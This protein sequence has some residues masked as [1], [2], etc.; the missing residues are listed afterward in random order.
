MRSKTRHGVFEI[1]QLE[2]IK[3][4]KSDKNATLHKNVAFL[5]KFISIIN[6]KFINV[7]FTNIFYNVEIV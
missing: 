4:I 5:I 3:Q 1:G 7:K 2:S 6:N